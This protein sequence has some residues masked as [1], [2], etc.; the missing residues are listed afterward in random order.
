MKEI[1][2]NYPKYQVRIIFPDEIVYFMKAAHIDE[3]EITNM[4]EWARLIGNDVF[5]SY[6]NQNKQKQ[7]NS[8]DREKVLFKSKEI[9]VLIHGFYMNSRLSFEFKASDFVDA[10]PLING[11]HC[12]KNGWYVRFA[13]F[14]KEIS[15]KKYNIRIN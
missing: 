9:I 15:I 1:I 2:N 11:N 13:Y 7:N 8:F 5:Y 10:K 14:D 12:F 4:T 6:E 3:K